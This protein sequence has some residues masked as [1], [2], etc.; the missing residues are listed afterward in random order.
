MELPLI[1]NEAEYEAAL[2]RIE[3]LFDAPNGTPECNELVA[4]A[5]LVE[6]YEEQHY[7][8]AASPSL[9]TKKAPR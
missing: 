1:R 4:L 2:A 9:A 8:I 3:L 5:A 6:A 7:P